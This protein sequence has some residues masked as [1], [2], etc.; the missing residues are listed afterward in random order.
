MHYLLECVCFS[1]SAWILYVKTIFQRPGI[2]ISGSVTVD[3]CLLLLFVVCLL[4]ALF[5]FIMILLF[6]FVCLFFGCVLY[7]LSYTPIRCAKLCIVII[8]R[9][10]IMSIQNISM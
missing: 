6:L 10:Q 2:T 7:N 8:S 1:V 3:C 5:L 4:F 9:G